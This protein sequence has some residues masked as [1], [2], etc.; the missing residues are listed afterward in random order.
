VAS[1]SLVG[2]A[3]LYPRFPEMDKWFVLILRP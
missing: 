3:T 2:P 1:S